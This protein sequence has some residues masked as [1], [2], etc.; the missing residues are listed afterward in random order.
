MK[1]IQSACPLDCWDA[2]S[3][4]ATTE[5][6]RIVSI[7]GDPDDPVTQG[8]LCSKGQKM[9]SRLSHPDRLTSPMKRTPEGWLPVSWDLALDEI[10]S[11]LSAIVGTHGS[12]S[13]IHY[14]EGGH[15]GLSKNIDTAFF[16]ALG[17]AVTP[18]GSLCW[19]AGI[20]AQVQDFGTSYTH[21]PADLLKTNCLLLW[22]RNPVVTNIHLT[23]FIRQLKAKG[24]PIYLIDPVR[25]ASASLA[26]HHFAIHPG[27]DGHLAILIAKLLIRKELV[28]H[29]FLRKHSLHADA[30]INAV[31]HLSFDNLLAATGLS[32]EQVVMLADA[33][34]TA[35]PA[36]IY[37]GYGMQRNRFGGRNTRLI[38]ALGA[39]TGNIGVS[40]GGVN[41]AHRYISR[42]IDSEYLE[43]TT[44]KPSPTFYRAD[45]SKYVL[46]Q[47]AG[48]IQGIV[49]TKSNPV[50][51]LPDT[52][53]TIKAFSQIPFKVVIDQFMTDTA[54]AADYVLPCTMMLEESD[55]M[56]SS[57]WHSR[58]TYTE[59]A[60]IPPEGVRHE[61][62]I[63]NALAKR[64][65]MD[66]FTQKYP[67]KQTYIARSIAPLCE[68]LGLSPEALRGKRMSVSG[69]AVPWEDRQ[70]ETPS[71][72][73][74]FYVPE[75]DGSFDMPTETNHN[76]PYRLL[77]VHA[78]ESLHSQHFHSF[79][80]TEPPEVRLHPET[81]ASEGL[82]SGAPIRLVSHYGFLDCHTLITDQ[83]QP[84][85]LVMKQGSWLRKGAVNMLTGPKQSDI[86]GQVTYHDCLCRIERIHG[87]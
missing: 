81:A 27:S 15:G 9:M 4:L 41:Y 65:E 78:A 75:P 63:F 25:T 18:I 31:Q 3:I 77:T 34:G 35:G 24:V 33:Y 52:G 5:N 19:G 43:N 74:T 85:V 67:D 48:A 1:T 79:D 60:S 62:D 83:Q 64:L 16:N 46:S 51:Q 32:L 87:N 70:F 76:F 39:L 73:F 36:S 61:F 44:K 59:Q 80:P 37:L 69:N 8:F 6:D 45:F 68:K 49:V 26:D 29:E 28:D 13:L 38:D 82:E 42:W 71:G 14:S 55:M 12:S 2:C 57:M 21:S 56:F 72:R 30:Y 7:E 53:N 23:P 17:G 11:R 84:G 66:E 86:G 20:A 58:F 54:S 22:G 10:G 40:G 50:V 47:P